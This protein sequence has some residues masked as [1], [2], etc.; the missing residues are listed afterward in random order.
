MSV[1]QQEAVTRSMKVSRCCLYLLLTNIC[2]LRPVFLSRSS[3]DRF[4]IRSKTDENAYKTQMQLWDQGKVL[5]RV[6]VLRPAPKSSSSFKSETGR[7]RSQSASGAITDCGMRHE[8]ALLRAVTEHHLSTRSG[9][10]RC[11]TC[12]CSRHVPCEIAVTHLDND[13]RRSSLTCVSAMSPATPYLRK[14]S[15]DDIV[16]RAKS[17][18]KPFLSTTDRREGGAFE[19]VEMGTSPGPGAYNLAISRTAVPPPRSRVQARPRL[20]QGPRFEASSRGSDVGPGYH[21]ISRS[22]IKKTFNITFG[23]ACCPAGASRVVHHRASFARKTK[24]ARRL[25]SGSP[26]QPETE[27]IPSERAT[28]GPR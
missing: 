6:V 22:L 17:K 19:A 18:S 2:F 26:L 25:S 14:D 8:C 3:G 10:S 16:E 5:K 7:F 21:D 11:S 20:P 4:R 23:G 15:F 1:E 12:S 24:D 13:I 28:C 27:N 9:Y